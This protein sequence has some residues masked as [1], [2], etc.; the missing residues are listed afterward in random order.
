MADQPA[1][2][3]GFFQIALG[4]VIAPPLIVW[5]QFQIGWRATFLCAGALGFPWTPKVARTRSA[6]A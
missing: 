4:S 5:L 1:K 6:A 3:L 2:E